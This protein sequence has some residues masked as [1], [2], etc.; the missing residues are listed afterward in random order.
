MWQVEAV[1]HLALLYGAALAG[2]VALLVTGKYGA[3]LML[4]LILFLVAFVILVYGM[5]LATL[6]FTEIGDDYVGR[7]QAI[8][9]ELSK[10]DV[11]A[12]LE[13][14]ARTTTTASTAGQGTLRRARL[15]A[16]I[17]V[18]IFS[19]GAVSLLL[20]LLCKAAT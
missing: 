10:G 15:C 20:T 11:G 5:H 12:T 2:A 13:F 8:D 14:A 18:W 16:W 17:S 9:K 7:I 1:R 6:G 3:S 19:I 4:A